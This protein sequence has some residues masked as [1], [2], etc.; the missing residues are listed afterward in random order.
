[1]IRWWVVGSEGGTVGVRE[2]SDGVRT[3]C[4]GLGG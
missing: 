4:G 2:L 3:W 1:M